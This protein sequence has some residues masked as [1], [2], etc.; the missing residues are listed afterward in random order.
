MTA[1]KYLLTR[2]PTCRDSCLT[3]DRRIS[4]SWSARTVERLSWNPSAWLAQTQVTEG[5]AN[6]FSTRKSL[7]AS[8]EAK[9]PAQRIMNSFFNWTAYLLAFVFLAWLLL[10]AYLL[11]FEVFDF[12]YFLRVHQQQ[13]QM[14]WVIEFV[15]GNH[16]LIFT[17]LTQLFNEFLASV[18]ILIVAF[19]LA[20]VTYAGQE[21]L[22]DT[23]AD[24]D[25]ICAFSSLFP[26]D[27]YDF[28]SSTGT[29]LDL[30]GLFLTGLA[31]S[32]MTNFLARMLSA[33]QW[34]AA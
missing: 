14:F 13:L 26:E 19:L 8:L 22:T 3:V 1:W 17:T 29:E 32:L 18:A 7:I 5:S 28:L 16:S 12:L 24:R 9:M 27:R 31:G 2:I 34:L 23:L 15:A 10:I 33:V 21:F 4:F 25:S 6:V 20:L 30:W 11:A